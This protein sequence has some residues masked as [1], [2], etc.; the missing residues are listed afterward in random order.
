M[1]GPLKVAKFVNV[2]SNR[3]CMLADLPQ[4]FASRSVCV[5]VLRPKLELL[6]THSQDLWE[7]NC[8]SKQS[9]SFLKNELTNS[10]NK[11]FCHAKKNCRIL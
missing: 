11:V 7:I 6:K 4:L 5:R 9:A 3:I 2:A 8:S 1:P 10:L